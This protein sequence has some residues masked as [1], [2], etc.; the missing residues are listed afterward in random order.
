MFGSGLEIKSMNTI[1]LSEAIFSFPPLAKTTGL[2]SDKFGDF[3]EQKKKKKPK[4]QIALRTPSLLIS[5]Y[6]LHLEYVKLHL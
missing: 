3:D 2:K 5:L 6:W 1:Y 4:K